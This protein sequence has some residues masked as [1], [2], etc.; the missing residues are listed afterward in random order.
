[1]KKIKRRRPSQ[2][3]ESVSS[4]SEYIGPW[5]VCTVVEPVEGSRSR[6]SKRERALRTRPVAV[7]REVGLGIEVVL[8]PV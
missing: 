7:R 8:I 1:V 4:G 6:M 3:P 2:R 5:Q